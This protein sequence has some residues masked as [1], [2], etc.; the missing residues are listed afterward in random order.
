MVMISLKRQTVLPTKPRQ[1]GNICLL[2]SAVHSLDD[3]MQQDSLKLPGRNSYRKDNN[4]IK[5]IV[6][7]MT[8]VIFSKYIET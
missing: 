1:E 7:T 6:V 5:P 2:N 4:L 8:Q 3:C